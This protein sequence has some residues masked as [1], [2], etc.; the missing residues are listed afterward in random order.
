[1]LGCGDTKAVTVRSYCRIVVKS[2]PLQLKRV[3]AT[4]GAGIAQLRLG[5]TDGTL[6]FPDIDYRRISLCQS[7][8]ATA[9]KNTHGCW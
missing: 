7:S 4:C 1:M 2:C 9:L 8:Y 5:E 3:A 6:L